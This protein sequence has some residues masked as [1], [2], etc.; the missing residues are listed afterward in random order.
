VHAQDSAYPQ[1]FIRLV[2]PFAPGGSTDAIGRKLATHLAAALGQPVVVENLAGAAGVIGC[3]AV[4]NASPDGYTLLMGTTGTHA[5][6]PTS[7]TRPAYDAQ[8]DFAPVGMVG[9]QPMGIAVHPK[10]P[11]RQLSELVQLIRTQP[12]KYAYASAGN[13]GIAHLSLELFLTLAGGLKAEHVPYKGGGPALQDVVAGHVPILSD[14][15]SSMVPY[16]RSGALRLLACCGET[17][18]PAMPDVPTA[19]EAGF[20]RMVTSTAGLLL[21]PSRTPQPVIERLAAAMQ[22]VMA[23]PVFLAE[24]QALGAQAETNTSPQKTAAFI[25]A[26]IAKWAPVVR[27]TGPTM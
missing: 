16:H 14:T 6:N 22:K 5:I 18:S 2:V 7:M 24:L 15:F 3:S 21:A 4:A 20:P 1:R 25:A 12:G 27:A 17:R 13:G 8:K 10:V 26:E 19:V 9:V 11:A 23:L